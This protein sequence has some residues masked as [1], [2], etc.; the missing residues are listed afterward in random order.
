[1]LFGSLTMVFGIALHWG[2]KKINNYSGV[3]LFKSL[4]SIKTCKYHF[5]KLIMPANI[6]DWDIVLQN[7]CNKN[8]FKIQ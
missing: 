5:Y 6:S 4:L 8:A 1:M 2:N 3:F 7:P